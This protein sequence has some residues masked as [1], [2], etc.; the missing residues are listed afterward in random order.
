MEIEKRKTLSPIKQSSEIEKQRRLSPKKQCLEI[1]TQKPLSPTEQNLEIEK[2]VAY[3]TTLL[4][5][6]DK[7]PN[8]VAITQPKEDIDT[9]KE[10]EKK[11]LMRILITMIN[12]AN[13]VDHDQSANSIQFD[14]EEPKTYSR[15]M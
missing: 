8:I 11:D 4:E 12:S 3:L 15:V 5:N 9:P 1:E 7:G 2:V 14:V 6:W 10:D 13:T